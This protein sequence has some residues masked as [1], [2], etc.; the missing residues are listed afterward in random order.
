SFSKVSIRSLEIIGLATVIVTPYNGSALS[1]RMTEYTNFL[2]PP[3]T[4]VLVFGGFANLE[5]RQ[6]AED[7]LCEYFGDFANVRCLESLKIFFPGET[8]SS[9]QITSRVA[10][11]HVDGVVILKPTASGT[12]SVYIPPTTET[13][14][15][16]NVSANTYVNPYSDTAYTNGT[17]NGSSTTHTYGGFSIHKPWAS[18]Q[19][20]LWST[21]DN[22]IA[23][24]ATAD[25]RG[26]GFAKW[27]D[28]IESAAE[29]T[30]KKLV[31]D[32]VLQP[33]HK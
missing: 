21:A 31:A 3:F 25:S 5:Q 12:S 33:R 4:T 15:T 23:W 18:F 30:A 19:A 16:A 13:S 22:K 11:L 27:D 7:Q 14:W 24:Y 17:V 10:E 26:G 6:Y 28:L 2:T 29:K 20:T 32:G 1:A 9:Q 8:Y